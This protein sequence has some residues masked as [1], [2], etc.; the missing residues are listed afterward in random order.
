MNSLFNSVIMT[1]TATLASSGC[2]LCNNNCMPSCW[3]DCSNTCIAAAADKCGNTCG[4]GCA[5]TC[6]GHSTGK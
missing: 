2:P 5:N 6:K 1:S 4:S 3:E